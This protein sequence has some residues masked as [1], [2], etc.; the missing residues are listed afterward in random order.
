MRTVNWTDVIDALE[1]KRDA[2]DIAIHAAKGMAEDARRDG[3]APAQVT[4]SATKAK[5][6]KARPRVT[7]TRSPRGSGPDRVYELL[8][9]HGALT[10]PQLTKRLGL[11]SNAGTYKYLAQLLKDGRVA[12]QNKA[13]G[14]REGRQYD[15]AS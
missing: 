5:G 8:K 12:R 7:R 1:L 10:V 2:I 4:P 15:I 11:V 13:L 14:W 3:P 9:T 6:P